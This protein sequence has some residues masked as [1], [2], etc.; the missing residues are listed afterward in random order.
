[1]IRLELQFTLQKLEAQCL[2]RKCD[3]LALELSEL[4]LSVTVGVELA[5]PVELPLSESEIVAICEELSPI[6]PVRLPKKRKRGPRKAKPVKSALEEDSFLP[7]TEVSDL[8]PAAQNTQDAIGARALLVEVMKRAAY[9]WVLYRN[10]LRLDQKRLAEDAYTWL[11]LEEEGHAAWRQRQ[12]EGKRLTSFLSICEDF[13]LDPEILR[14][15]F[16]TLTPKRVLSF[17]RPPSKSKDE[18][19]DTELRSF[20]TLPPENDEFFN[21]G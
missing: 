10:S 7:R 8:D 19:L 4:L 9:D 13:D 11:F 3:G 16:R 5:E 14:D 2:D 17:G 21:I 1:M 6:K 15:R 18:D 20:V 12:E